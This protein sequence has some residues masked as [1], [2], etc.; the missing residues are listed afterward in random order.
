[1]ILERTDLF[2]LKTLELLREYWIEKI[3]SIDIE[4]HVVKNFMDNEFILGV[5]FAM[6][7]SGE[8]TSK[9][10]IESIT[11]I[12][13]DENDESEAKLLRDINE[14][15]SK[16]KPLGT[17]GYGSRGYDIPWLQMKNTKHQRNINKPL[18]SLIDT[19]QDAVHVDLYFLLRTLY[20]ARNL[21]AVLEVPELQYLPLRKSK[22]LVSED[23][24]QKGKDIVRMWQEDHKSFIKYV[25]ADAI[26]PLL[27]AEHLL[28]N[29]GV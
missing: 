5:S 18:W 2:N 25:E 23:F 29:R 17:I 12:S 26:N 28:K 7:T 6:R 8:L 22:G 1:L 27:I 9:S 21:R 24:D 13:D 20:K 19:L 3:V 10:G 4:T 15:L 14:W 16:Y 11:F